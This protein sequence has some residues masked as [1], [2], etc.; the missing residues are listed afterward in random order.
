MEPE[1][2]RE[3]IYVD[4]PM[5]SWCWGIAPELTDLRKRR[6]DLGFR[7]VLGGLRPGPAAE[8]MTDRMA[9]SLRHHWEQVAGRTG[10]PFDQR[11]LDRR[12]WTY[13]TEPACRAVVVVRTLEPD[14][15]WP[16]FER[17]QNGF[18]AE[19]SVLQDTDT[20]ARY[21]EQIGGDGEA[22]RS[23]FGTRAA[24]EATWHDFS[25]ARS[26]GITGF[27]TIV[28]RDGNRGTLI[29]AGYATASDM[30]MAL[31]SALPRR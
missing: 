20:L 21:A 11:L 18:Y 2:D 19:G 23:T 3:I 30:E 9:A 15:A 22:F 12:D 27:P 4:D 26:W 6:P 13:D 29:S 16:M 1:P 25:L 10:Q 24:I 14:L 31:G 17:L 28:A 7:I 5:C 8:E